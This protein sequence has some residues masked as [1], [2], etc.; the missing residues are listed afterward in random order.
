[1]KQ[2]EMERPQLLDLYRVVLTARQIDLAEQQLNSRG[3]A[4]FHLSGA[5]H[6]GA[7]VLARHLRTEDWLHCM[8]RFSTTSTFSQPP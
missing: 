6:E 8:A 7:A 5:G 3:E 2:H 1:M 4:F